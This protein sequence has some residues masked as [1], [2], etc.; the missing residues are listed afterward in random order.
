MGLQN[1]PTPP[2]VA[3]AAATAAGSGIPANTVASTA[4]V[5]MALTSLTASI[6]QLM[7][8]SVSC[9]Q[10]CGAPMMG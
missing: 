8:N 5:N 3:S 4:S 9:N 6:T 7:Q 1:L 10:Q 2:V